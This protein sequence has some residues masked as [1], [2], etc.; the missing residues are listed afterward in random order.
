[1]VNESNY[2]SLLTDENAL[3]VAKW[4]VDS[5]KND[6]NQ[7][8]I[9]H[10]FD[11]SKGVMKKVDINT[12][13]KF[14]TKE[15]T[16][17]RKIK[18]VIFSKE[19]E[20]NTDVQ[21]SDEAKEENERYEKEKFDL[22]LEWLIKVKSIIN[23]KY[24][25]ELREKIR[26]VILKNAPPQLFPLN[27]V[28]V[29]N[30]ELTDPDPDGNY[31]IIVNKKG[32]TGSESGAS[33]VLMQEHIDTGKSLDVIISEKKAEGDPRFQYITGAYKKKFI[34]ECEVDIYVDFSLG[35]KYDTQR[36]N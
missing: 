6:G 31:I 3:E 28:E 24:I 5:F 20:T 34:Y 15:G 14:D 18:E 1:M 25:N 12:W 13:Y 4:I 30:L 10:K 29:I 16:L 23:D 26:E 7:D 11:I 21:L 8:N 36:I 2:K 17:L 33:A 22:V 19:K 32:P 9:D 27:R 35:P